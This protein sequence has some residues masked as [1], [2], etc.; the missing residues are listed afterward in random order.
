L[1]QNLPEFAISGQVDDFLSGRKPTRGGSSDTEL[2]DPT[3]STS[4]DPSSCMA[5]TAQTPVG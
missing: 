1:T 2:N 3:T 4:G 5:V